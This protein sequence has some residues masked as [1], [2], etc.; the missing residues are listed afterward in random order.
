VSETP[1]ER[2]VE[3]TWASLRRRK[4]VQW[5]LAYAAGAWVLLQV[6]GFAADAFAWQ[7]L[8]KQLAM[9]ALVLG[10]PV[11]LALAWY[12]GDRGQQRVTGS[13]LA[14]LTLLLFVGG[15]LLWLYAHHSEPTTTATTDAKPVAPSAS[16]DPRPSIAVLPFDNMSA[17]KEQ[18]Y[19]ADG[20]SEELLNLLAQ[21]AGL[22]VI[23]RTSSFSFKDQ[24]VEIAEIARRLNVANVLEGSV[25]KSGDTVRITAQLV[26]ASD[27]SHLWSQT[28]D[29]QMT[30]IFHVQDEIAAAVVA[31][32]QVKLLGAAPKTRSVDPEAYPLFL[33]ARQIARQYTAAALQN[34]IALYKRALAID[35]SYAAA[36][37]G[38]AF[39]YTSQVDFDLLLPDEGY[40]LAREALDKAL[41]IDSQL[42]AAHASLGWISIQER[43]FG[44][45]ARHIEHALALE[46]TNNP[47]I[48]NLAAVLARRI[49]RLDQAIEI[50]EYLVAIDPAN[51]TV[52]SDLSYAYRYAGRLDEAIAASRTALSLSPGFIW[53]HRFNAEILLQKGES[54]SALT[55]MQEEADEQTRLTG[56]SMVYHAL[57]R[58]AESDA[59]LADAIEKYEKTSAQPIAM[60]L[61]F[62]GEADRAF[63]W[64]DKAV[65]YNDTD[66]GGT[67]VHP[68]FA[69]IH[70]D[71]RWLPFLRRI[72]MAPEQ[73]AAI[74]FDVEMPK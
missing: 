13:E 3:S 41:E 62:R 10:L 52:H 44:A 34:S 22:R 60:A 25:R 49:G 65:Q 59:V 61:A 5:G 69:N 26:R 12:H 48:L 54:T 1:T 9:L 67:A 38:L 14:V 47:D 66:L 42:A 68:M 17:D 53:R 27:S 58:K 45:A 74:K 51:V 6:V 24:N 15:G 29:R 18:D 11:V 2:D 8:I 16:A 4:V 43:D 50:G 32:L 71:P 21:V 33:Q 63:E 64:L 56:L 40:R 30:D 35:P 28:Y 7:P 36:W 70:A 73:L 55:E 39:N 72:G 31:E 19:F 37:E 23:A 57:G 46:P 20:I